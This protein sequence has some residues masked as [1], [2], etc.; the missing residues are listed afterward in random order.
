M[1]VTTAPDARHQFQIVLMT[2]SCS[3]AECRASLD[4]AIAAPAFIERRTLLVD[5]READLVTVD[6]VD[7]MV[8]FMA[9]RHDVLVGARMAIVTGSDAS[10]GMCRMLQLKVEARNPD[11]AIR[12]CR[13]YDEAVAW[14]SVPAG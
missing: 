1:P 10:F 4:E 9:S 5:R 13:S 11:I 3:V 14:L 6:F 12:P 2:K 7:E 8:S